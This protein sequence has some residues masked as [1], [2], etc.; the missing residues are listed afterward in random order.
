MIKKLLLGGL[1]L[2]TLLGGTGC[3][4]TQSVDDKLKQDPFSLTPEEVA[5]LAGRDWEGTFEVIETE[6]GGS[7][8]SGRENMN[9]Y[10]LEE[11][12]TH[13]LFALGI[14]EEGDFYTTFPK[15]R[16]GNLYFESILSTKLEN[17]M[18]GSDY[19]SQIIYYARDS[20]LR[21]AGNLDHYDFKNN[22]EDGISVYIAIK[23]SAIDQ[24]KEAVKLSQLY[25]SLDGFEFKDVSVGYFREY[26][27][28]IDKFL[29]FDT[30]GLDNSFSVFDQALIQKI[31]LSSSVLD[32]TITPEMVMRKFKE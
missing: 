25:N 8:P 1:L 7:R 21:D 26:P 11:K 30:T 12:N 32:E 17:I 28:G 10:L 29:V 23:S 3:K 20:K 15:M 6:L 18:P 19:K 27:E 24:E 31:D 14:K 13:T 9:R 16:L 22:R 4:M 5:E 2:L